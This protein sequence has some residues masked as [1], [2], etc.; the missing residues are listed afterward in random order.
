[1]P[2]SDEP[3]GRQEGHQNR[4]NSGANR[5]VVDIEIEDAEAIA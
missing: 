5:R 3:A 2:L 4:L 1:L